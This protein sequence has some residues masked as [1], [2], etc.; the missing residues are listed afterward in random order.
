MGLDAVN[1]FLGIADAEC[2]LA[3]AGAVM[4]AVVAK[5]M[6]GRPKTVERATETCLLLCELECAEVVVAALVDKGTKHKVPK[7]ALASVEALR[8]A[9]AAQA[10]PSLPV[11]DDDPTG[12][13]T[14][15]GVAVR[16]DWA[17]LSGEL[18]S[19]KSCFYLLANTRA[20]D[21]AAAVA[22]NRE[23]GR[24]LRR[25]GPRLVV[26]RSDSTLRGHF[27]AEVDALADG[28][29]WR[30]PLVQV[31]PQVVGGGAQ[32]QWRINN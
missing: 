8:A 25:G 19:D 27:P 32:D 17:D 18:R 6:S 28:L 29:G 21:E 15:H 5:G 10:S 7:C 26:S 31:A 13:Q 23:I 22:R 30:R 20:L 2:A 4:A 9:L 12:T 3:R 11:V 14:V 1:A 24:E 16:A